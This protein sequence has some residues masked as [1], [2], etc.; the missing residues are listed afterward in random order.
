MTSSFQYEIVEKSYHQLNNIY[1]R[2]LNPTNVAN[3]S[4]D[5]I[6]KLFLSNELFVL[7]SSGL[8]Y[9]ESISSRLFNSIHYPNLVVNVKFFERLLDSSEKFEVYYYLFSK[10]FNLSGNSTK[11]LKPYCFDNKYSSSFEL[12]D[13]SA[14]AYT[15]KSTLKKIRKY[16]KK[17]SF[18][19]TFY[20]IRTNSFFDAVFPCSHDYIVPTFLKYSPFE[21][22]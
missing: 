20:S 8:S 17:T 12:L 18:I 4:V 19:K 13:G 22:N 10:N 6:E 2:S 14:D 1:I 5:A 3:L 9:I 15:I 7:D 11:K 21:I 16:T